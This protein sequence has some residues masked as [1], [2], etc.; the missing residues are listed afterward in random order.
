MSKF[1]SLILIIGL[2][3]IAVTAALLTVLVLYATGTIKTNPIELVY[4]VENAE[5]D[6]DGT[7]LTGEEYKL[8]SGNILEGHTAQVKV[9]G[10][11]TNAGESEATLEVKIFDKKGFDVTGEYA[12]KVNAGTLKVVQRNISVV[13]SDSSVT[14]S[15]KEV[16][17]N[18]YAITEGEL[19]KGHKIAG[20]S[21]TLLKVGDTLPEDTEPLIYDAFDNDVTA[22]YNIYFEMGNVAVTPRLIT[23]KPKDVSKIYDGTALEA[24]EY[25]IVEGS[26]A[27]GQTVKFRITTTSGGE[28]SLVNYVE[29]GLR[30]TIDRLSFEILAD[31]GKTPVTENYEITYESALL[32]IVPRSITLSTADRNFTYN[33]EEQYDRNVSVIGALAPNQH[34]GVIGCPTVQNVTDSAVNEV[35]YKIYDA[36]GNEVNVSNYS[37][38]PSWG[39]LT[40]SPMNLTVYTKSYSKVYDGEPL[41]SCVKADEKIYE[42]SPAL[43][44]KFT[45][46]ANHNGILDKTDAESGSYVL[47][48]EIEMLTEA[49]TGNFNISVISG[50][51][52]ISKKP[53]TVT[54]QSLTSIYDG[55]K[56]EITADNAF[57]NTEL[58]KYKVSA[59]DFTIKPLGDMTSATVHLYTAAFNGEANNYDLSVTQG[60]VTISRR[61]VTLQTIGYTTM[62]YNGAYYE[63][64]MTDLSIAEDDRYKIISA[65]YSKSFDGYK[66][67]FTFT[68]VEV[69]FDGKNVTSNLEI[70]LGATLA[71][72]MTAR[73][74][75]FAY[76]SYSGFYYPAKEDLKGLIQVAADTPL[77][78]GDSLTVTEIETEGYSYR[79]KS[80]KVENKDFGDVGKYYVLDDSAYGNI[81]YNSDY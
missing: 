1:R 49:C 8:E 48:V 50:R 58:E 22:N 17:F 57:D 40:V 30:T 29:N 4:S 37:V 3:L 39:T 78:Q 28:A 10:S 53:V 41:K 72:T 59:A 34:L 19:L 54:L 15:G 71:V 55:N 31:D 68:A 56:Y 65:A 66:Q 44:A 38:T 7:P 46:I 9:I 5:K 26:L 63:V 75:S 12:I 32:T 69:A 51:Y 70:D 36:D 67:Q 45:L 6:Y 23:V 61:K 77:G 79:V 73:T 47:G 43:P 24:T 20:F 62:T 27:V 81:Y 25:E 16:F 80:I 76:G 64:K 42:T 52:E 35:E 14:Y 60:T 13:I 2:L 18:D 33:G 21:T 74:I 11:Q